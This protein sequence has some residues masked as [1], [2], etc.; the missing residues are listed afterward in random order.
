MK[1]QSALGI[2]L[3]SG[4]GGLSTGFLDAGLH[5]TAGFE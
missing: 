1:N 5:V 3:F 2:E 4:C